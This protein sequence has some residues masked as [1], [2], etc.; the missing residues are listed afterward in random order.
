MKEALTD[1][2][3]GERDRVFNAIIKNIE[4]AEKFQEE[5]AKKANNGEKEYSSLLETAAVLKKPLNSSYLFVVD[6]DIKPFI[7]G[8]YLCIIPYS[9]ATNSDFWVDV[10]KQTISVTGK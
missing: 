6:E 9:P 1:H 5:I 3:T 8:R 2:V 7:G 10:Q 4:L